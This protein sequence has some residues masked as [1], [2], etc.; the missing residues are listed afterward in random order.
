MLPCQ[1]VNLGSSHSDSPNAA[2]ISNAEEK[3]T[4]L[5]ASGIGPSTYVVDGAGRIIIERLVMRTRAIEPVD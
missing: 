4:I 2:S 1:N 3:V 5:G